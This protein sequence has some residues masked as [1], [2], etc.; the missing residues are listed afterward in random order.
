VGRHVAAG[1]AIYSKAGNHVGWFLDNSVDVAERLNS[2]YG[3]AVWM[4]AAT[5]FACI[6]LWYCWYFEASAERNFSGSPIP[7][8]RPYTDN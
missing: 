2:Y 1:S 6:F 4:E 7:I 3:W 8:F 5:F